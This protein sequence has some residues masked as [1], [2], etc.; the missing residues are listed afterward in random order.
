MQV[1]RK[2]T[3]DGIKIY[4]I[5]DFD[6]M[7]NSCNLAAKTLDMINEHVRPGITTDELDKI[8]HDFIILNNA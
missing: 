7:R 4:N 5:D 8:C 1:E 3:R 2:V 6:G